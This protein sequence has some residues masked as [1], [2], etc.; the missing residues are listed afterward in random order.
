MSVMAG[1]P[2]L[3]NGLDCLPTTACHKSPLVSPSGIIRRAWSRI[4]GTD[5]PS[6]PP[7]QRA[8]VQVDLIVPMAVPGDLPAVLAE[9]AAVHS[10]SQPVARR[11]MIPTAWNQIAKAGRHNKVTVPDEGK[12]DFE[13]KI[14]KVMSD[15]QSS[16]DGMKGRGGL[17][18][19]P[20]RVGPAK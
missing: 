11:E 4:G 18:K 9:R 10:D 19:L 5:A 16:P 6:R 15:D 20:P 7:T 13:F 14:P 2:S 1:A 8:R 17:I 12:T 3:A